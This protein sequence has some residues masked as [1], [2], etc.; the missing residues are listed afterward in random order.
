MMGRAVAAMVLPASGVDLDEGFDIVLDPGF[1]VDLAVEAGA[2]DEDDAAFDPCTATRAIVVELAVEDV[3]AGRAV[4][5]FPGSSGAVAVGA[6]VDAWSHA[7]QAG[8]AGAEVLPEGQGEHGIVK[9]AEVEPGVAGEGVGLALLVE[10]VVA[11]DLGD[12]FP[13]FGL[14]F[15]EGHDLAGVGGFSKPT[16]LR[17]QGVGEESQPEDQPCGNVFQALLLTWSRS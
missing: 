7:L 4:G 12:N 13:I 3:E 1:A 9:Q 2:Y 15:V 16:A 17:G 11:D 10:V 8:G 5:E 14:E 6:L